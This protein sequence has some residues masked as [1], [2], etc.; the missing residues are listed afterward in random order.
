MNENKIILDLDFDELENDGFSG[1]IANS[2]VMNPAVRYEAYFYNDQ[3]FL[4]ADDLKY[5]I[6]SVMMVPDMLIPKRSPYGIVYNRFK[7]EVV[8]KSLNYFMQSG[9]HNILSFEHM[10]NH[11][12]DPSKVYLKSIYQVDEHT[13]NSKY[14]NLPEGTIIAVYK[15][16]D[17]ELY[18]ALL[19]NDF[20]GFSIEFV[21]KIMYNVDELYDLDIE[22]ITKILDSEMSVDEQYMELQKLFVSK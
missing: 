14:V 21:G 18:K 13:T 16:V 12:N 17:T 2:I 4:F 15:F 19:E 8:D 20:K 5:E 11:I 1:I 10:D 3:K 9:K 6:E 7:R 22:D